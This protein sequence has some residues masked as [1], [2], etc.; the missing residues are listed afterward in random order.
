LDVPR[1]IPADLAERYRQLRDFDEAEVALVRALVRRPDRL[2]RA[3]EH[4]LRAALNLARLW[5]IRE[6]ETEAVVGPMLGAIRERLRPLAKAIAKDSDLDPQD[7]GRDAEALR[8]ALIE[9]REAIVSRHVGRLLPSA[10]DRELGTKSLVLVLGGG[11]GCGY[12]HL[13]SFSV[14]ESLGLTPK[15][16]AGS[17]M[18]SI[19]GLFR[20]REI[21]YRDATVRAV[22]HGLTFKKLFRIFDSE[23]RY[24]I[25]G[26][27]RLYLRSA[28]S[29]FFVNQQ[30]ETMRIHEMPIPFICVVTGLRREALRREKITEYERAFEREIR[31]G[32]IGA[33]LHIKDLIQGF[34]SLM[35]DLVQTPGATQPVSLGLDAES[36]EFDVI[37]AVG[38]SCAMPSL[39]HYDILRDD[40][41]MHAMMHS[42]LARFSIDHL[43]DGGVSANV[44]A[45]AAWEAV[46]RGHIGTRNAFI[47]GL[48]CFAPQIRRNMLFLPLQR[49]AAENV[50]Q[51]RLFAHHVFTYKKVLSPAALV[52]SP[53]NVDTA[54][55]NGRTEFHEQSPFLL[56]MMEPL[57]PIG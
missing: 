5:V 16:I 20:S 24:G 40:P 29:R 14:L 46:Q 32:A 55:E 38:F 36:R 42:T 12:V 43:I 48:D 7:V 3:Q 31:S 11:G 28:I 9:A 15:L 44:P 50:S 27:L 37:D 39:I 33:L 10:F 19:L 57:P 26:P 54:L 22:T 34:A 56:K 13:G 25:P 4:L 52:P 41:R 47:L 35:A 2:P 45:R 49:I 23:V 8:P 1:D 53:K 18:G 6:G 21:R 17:S 30:G 51:D